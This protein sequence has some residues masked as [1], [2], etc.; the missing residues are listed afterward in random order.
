META[1]PADA[2]GPG[3]RLVISP[4]S[5]ASE[6]LAA[7]GLDVSAPR[8]IGPQSWL[9]RQL[10]AA[11]PAAWWASHTGLPP[12]TLLQLAAATDWAMPLQLGWTDAAIRDQHGPWISAFLDQP[13]HQLERLGDERAIS[14]FQALTEPDRDVWL[15]AH[16][17]SSLFSAIELVPGPWSAALSAVVRERIAALARADPGRSP[18][19][20]RLL[21]VAALRLEPPDPPQLDPAGLHPQLAGN[22]A[23]LIRNLSVRAAMRRELAEEPNL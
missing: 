13:A 17:D 23:E 3:P 12:A 2:G 19:A 6:E 11:P 16:P 7:D 18:Q 21:R 4:P 5:A 20:R 9:L 10:V 1:V 14:L 15:A 8:G 22:W